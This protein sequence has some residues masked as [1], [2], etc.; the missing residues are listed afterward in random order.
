MR[1]S[2]G[3]FLLSSWCVL[4]WSARRAY[5]FR[6]FFTEFW[7]GGFDLGRHQRNAFFSVSVP[8]PNLAKGLRCLYF[9]PIMHLRSLG[10]LSR[11]GMRSGFLLSFP[12]ECGR[13]FFLKR[14]PRPSS[15]SFSGAPDGR[16]KLFADAGGVDGA[17]WFLVS[18]YFS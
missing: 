14:G 17:I 2:I 10:F 5:A 3:V 6:V 1:L 7:V 18:F 4:A 15:Q 16:C 13:V 12:A 9:D 11:T 8:K